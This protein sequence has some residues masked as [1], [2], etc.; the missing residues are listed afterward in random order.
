MNTEQTEI[1]Y[2]KREYKYTKECYL[3][4]K[5]KI[6]ELSQEQRELKPQRKCDENIKV[7][8]T[9]TQRSAIDGVNSNKYFLRLMFVLYDQIRGKE[10]RV[11]LEKNKLDSY[12]LISL[13]RLEKEYLEETKTL[14]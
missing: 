10:Q 9:V 1:V 6:K 4:L 8:R 2:N 7:A 12:R 11:E 14:S 5:N 13:K 3:K